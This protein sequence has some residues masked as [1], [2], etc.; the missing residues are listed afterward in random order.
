MPIE[1][2]VNVGGTWEQSR[3]VYT[4]VSG[5]FR[6]VDE[7]HTKVAGVWEQVYQGFFAD[8][9]GSSLG[10]VDATTA[11]PVT[12]AGNEGLSPYTF[13][14]EY[15]S[16]DTSI[17]LDGSPTAAI[18]NWSVPSPRDVQAVWRCTVTDSYSRAD[19]FTKTVIFLT[20]S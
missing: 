16:G 1:T 8:S 2:H 17:T 5:T 4:K 14:W 10:A 9:T 11:G 3:E 13:L 20:S 6:F 18:A 7:I 15:V 19:S 12:A